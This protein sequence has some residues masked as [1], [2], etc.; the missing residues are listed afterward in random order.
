ML[1][2]DMDQELRNYAIELFRRAAILTHDLEV[3]DFSLFSSLF[4]LLTAG[5][6]P[7][8]YNFYHKIFNDITE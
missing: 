2:G 7:I 1:S 3:R 4:H 6:Y 8:F 5:Y